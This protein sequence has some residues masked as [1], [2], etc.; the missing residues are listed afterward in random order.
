MYTADASWKDRQ[1]Q[2]VHEPKR[3]EERR[4]PELALEDVDI[5][6]RN[7]MVDTTIKENSQDLVFI[8][9]PFWLHRSGGDE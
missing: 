6:V 8:W 2:R 4:F 3:H 9:R 1:P 7:R 5:Q